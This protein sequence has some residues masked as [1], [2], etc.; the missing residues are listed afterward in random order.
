MHTFGP[1]IL[2]NI[3]YLK[4]TSSSLSLSNPPLFPSSGQTIKII[5]DNVEYILMVMSKMLY[6]LPFD[7]ERLFWSVF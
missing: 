5:R 3:L 6:N 1:V 2:N 4:Y 7:I